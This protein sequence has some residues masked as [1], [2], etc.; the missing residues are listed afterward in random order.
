M[1]TT[2][3]SQRRRFPW[4]AKMLSGLVCLLVLL[5]IGAFALAS[6][7]K[8]AWDSAV[9]DLRASGEPVTFTDIEA[10][11]PAVA[12]EDNGA[13]IIR[14]LGDEIEAATSGVDESILVFGDVKRDL[15]RGIS[16]NSL[17]PSR[18]FVAEHRSLIDSL[19]ALG[20]T[21][22]GRYEGE[23]GEAWWERA[24]EY[25]LGL[26]RSA[27]KLLALDATMNVVEGDNDA[28]VRALSL[29]RHLAQSLDG[30]PTLICKLVQ[31][32]CDALCIQSMEGV[33]YAATLSDAQVDQ[34][35]DL[36]EG[37]SGDMQMSLRGE[38]AFLV[39]HIDA[40]YGK[41]TTLL[42]VG[43]PKAGLLMKVSMGSRAVDGLQT[44]TRLVEAGHQPRMLLDRAR[45]VLANAEKPGLFESPADLMVP[46]VARACE[47]NARFVMHR[48]CAWVA[49]A[50]ERYR[51]ATGTF[52][53]TLDLLV[54]DYIEAVPEDIYDGKPMKLA[55]TE[56]GIVIYSVDEDGVDNGGQVDI[57][58]TQRRPLD[59][60]FRL[61][62]PELR[63]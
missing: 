38:R 6:R 22:A 62:H 16:R 49:L 45:T 30:S 14:Q 58:E 56:Y 28:A 39:A 51:M 50:A 41:P 35:A 46:A 40:V 8:A 2:E 52:P 54:P 7:G 61:R 59:V 43:L 24:P 42:G 53:E 18:E 47:L 17:E 12:D 23:P 10:D 33:L 57:S 20:D 4:W 1:T 26:V 36:V 37:M 5:A 11:R 27:A 34:L 3:S 25:D 60:G 19:S 21:S 48:K 32:A 29:Q 44:M 31:I 13:L 9:A 63:K 15:V 55:T